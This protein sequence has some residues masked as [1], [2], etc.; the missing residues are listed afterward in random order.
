MIDPGIWERGARSWSQTN[1]P[2]S[3]QLTPAV[4]SS[5][6]AAALDVLVGEGCLLAD[7]LFALRVALGDNTAGLPGLTQRTR[8]RLVAR[9][10][11][12][13]PLWYLFGGLA[14]LG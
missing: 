10:I 6:R 14:P 5:F 8:Q 3:L 2:P 11:D 7:H 1:G 13:G 12:P 9:P 4:S